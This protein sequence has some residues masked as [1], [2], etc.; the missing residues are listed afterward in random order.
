MQNLAEIVPPTFEADYMLESPL[1]CPRCSDEISIIRVVRLLRA[2]VNFTSTLPRKGYLVVCP[3]CQAIISF[4][5]TR[6][7]FLRPCKPSQALHR[8][9][10]KTAM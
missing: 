9:P 4:L 3:S 8:L 5:L 2:K 6:C 7:G 1:Q 10:M